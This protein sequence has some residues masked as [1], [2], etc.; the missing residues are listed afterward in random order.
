MQ[1]WRPE[2]VRYDMTYRKFDISCQY[3]ISKFDKLINWI[4]YPML[5]HTTRMIHSTVYHVLVQR[6]MILHDSTFGTCDL[7]IPVYCTSILYSEVAG[8]RPEDRAV[9]LITAFSCTLSG[10][11]VSLSSNYIHL[12]HYIGVYS[13]VLRIS[14]GRRQSL[15][16]RYDV[17]L[18]HCPEAEVCTECSYGLCIPGTR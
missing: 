17:L 5:D 6:R 8:R 9:A 18:L 7:Y 2:H 10:I 3:D 4:R 16:S 13:A 14:P 1:R 12:V 15:P 11:N